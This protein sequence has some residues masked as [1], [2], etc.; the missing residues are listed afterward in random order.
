MQMLV[1]ET[2]RYYHQYLETIAEGRSP[3][4]DV[5]ILEMYLFVSIVLQVGPKR[6]TERLLVHTR[7]VLYGILQKQDRFL[8]ILRFLHFSDHRN[9]P[10][11]TDENYDRLWK[12]RT[13]FDKLND[14]YAKTDCIYQRKTNVLG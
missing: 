14:A 1:E 11:K 13:I 8:H 7:T 5:T 4:P 6:Q 9:E 10:D 12:M 3:L 2:N